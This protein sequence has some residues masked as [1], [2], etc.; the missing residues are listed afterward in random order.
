MEFALADYP[1]TNPAPAHAIVLAGTGF[2][3]L[4]PGT[5]VQDGDEFCNLA[6]R[7]VQF[8]QE[9]VGRALPSGYIA[10]RSTGSR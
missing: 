3:T 8:S 7:F 10:R 5:T 1:S 2:R 6:G 4:E 9:L